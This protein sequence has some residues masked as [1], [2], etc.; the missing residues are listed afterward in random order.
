MAILRL[1]LHARHQD[2][3]FRFDFF[4]CHVPFLAFDACGPTPRV[5]W[6][7]VTDYSTGK[8]KKVPG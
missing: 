2:A 6:S 4:E 5:I 3:E 8:S 7:V 1:V